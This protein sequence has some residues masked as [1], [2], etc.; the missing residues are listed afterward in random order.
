MNDL[1]SRVNKLKK[2][3]IGDLMCKTDTKV[4]RFDHECKQQRH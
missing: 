1:E 3:E 2:I 4:K